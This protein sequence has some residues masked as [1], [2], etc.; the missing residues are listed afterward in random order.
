MS[1][2]LRLNLI[3]ILAAT[4]SFVALAGDRTARVEVFGDQGKA[5]SAALMQPRGS[6]TRTLDFDVEEGTNIS[7]GVSPHGD[8]LVFDLLG[9]LYRVGSKGGVAEALTQ[10]SGVAL[11]ITPAVSAD[12]QHIAFASDRSGQLN[13]WMMNA[14]GSAP[15]ALTHDKDAR[16][17]DPSWAPDGRSIAVVRRSPV[18]GYGVYFPRTEIWLIP[19][20][21]SVP[22]VLVQPAND[23]GPPAELFGAPSFSPDNKF[24]YFHRSLDS[25]CAPGF[26]NSRYRLRRLDL[27]SGEVVDVRPAPAVAKFDC[28][29]E[30][31]RTEQETEPRVS[32]DGRFLAFALTS[33]GETLSHRGHDF[34]PGTALMIRDLASGEERRLASTGTSLPNAYEEWLEINP[35]SISWSADG[36]SVVHA[37]AGRIQRVDVASGQ[38]TAVAFRAHVHRVISQQLR[39]RW[40]VDT[41]DSFS[42]SLLQWPS[43]SP[44]GRSLVFI[45]AGKL[46][47]AQHGGSAKQLV[48]DSAIGVGAWLYTPSWS[49]SGDEVAFASWDAKSAGHIWRYSLRTGTLQQVTHEAGRYLYP[50]WS[51]DGQTFA[52]LHSASPLRLSPQMYDSPFDEGAWDIVA[53]K[54]DPQMH[55]IATTERPH[56]IAF[57]LD[58]RLRY[59][60]RDAS[61][62]NPGGATKAG[63]PPEDALNLESIDPVTLA[64]RIEMQIVPVPWYWPETNLSPD[65]KWVSL[66]VSSRVFACDMSKLTG[67]PRRLD[68][69]RAAGF[70]SCQRLDRNGAWFS[71]WRDA[72]TVEFTEGSSQISVDVGRGERTAWPVS[73]NLQR[74]KHRDL[75]LSNATVIPLDGRQRSV[76]GDILI[77]DRRIAC[78]GKCQATPATQVIDASGKFIIPGLIDTHDHTTRVPSDIT[79]PDEWKSRASLAYGVTTRYDPFSRTR[80][81]FP[82]ADLTETGRLIG[83]RTYASADAINATVPGGGPVT[84]FDYEWPLTTAADAEFEVA[85]RARLGSPVLKYY[86]PWSREQGQLVLSAARA[87]GHVG[88]T[89]EGMSMHQELAWVM[90]GQS[91]FEHAV[92]GLPVYA[93]VT[94]FLG[95][96]GVIYTPTIVVEAANGLRSD[97]QLLADTGYESFSSAEVVQRYMQ[98]SRPYTVRQPQELTVDIQAETA[99]DIAGYGGRVSVGSHGELPG[100]A[101]HAEMW[102]LSAA[103]GPLEALRAATLNGAYKLGMDADLGSIEVGKVGD[104]LVL[105]AN[106]L[107]NIRNTTSI[108]S[109]VLGGAVYPQ[110]G[111]RNAH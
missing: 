73:V 74:P 95:M 30:R 62:A 90:D 2:V 99:R 46:W 14:D 20:D 65:G 19:T 13:L 51:N 94:K 67:S 72:G 25:V 102:I 34:R 54:S 10:G 83:P 36:K 43:T 81:N 49:P 68:I 18:R 44:D 79:Y 108:H 110:V 111:L 78:V 77:V 66:L 39:P 60:R 107:E 50:V 5:A 12:G 38:D 6:N 58:G 9:H 48:D 31:F 16:Y 26:K 87:N 22:R 15:V 101:A 41:R 69:G 106:P 109:I 40:P 61:A 91:M 56:R 75:L 103:M 17:V 1:A 97:A 82:L 33:M 59:L 100:L 11:N 27:A 37:P 98:F 70:D 29:T 80:I 93:D 76:R 96:A 32:P 104:L 88:V 7:L 86:W 71:S 84:Y 42:P 3:A 23:S 28:D 8:W 45:A 85:W 52:Y 64:K 105:D 57:G 53:G 63:S 55:M 47:I 35:S 21:G 24:L 89:S 92:A 4:T